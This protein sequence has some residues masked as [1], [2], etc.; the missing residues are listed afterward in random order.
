VADLIIIRLHPIKP[1]DSATFTSYLSKLTISAFDLTFAETKKGVPIGQATGVWTPASNNPADPKLKDFSP[2][3]PGIF[4][5]FSIVTSGLSQTVELEAVA[6]AVIVVNAPVGHT[7]YQTSDLHLEILNN[8]RKVL[9]ERLE[10]NV[11]IVK[12]A[13]LSINPRDYISAA[14]SVF[15]GLPDPGL[16]LNPGG[17]AFIDLPADGKAPLFSNVVTNVNIVLGKDPGGGASLASKSPLTA[18]QARQVAREITWNRQVSPPPTPPTPSGS[19]LPRPRPL[20]EMYTRP[21]TTAGLDVQKA[22][23]DREQFEASLSGF[24]ATQ[25]AKADRVAKYVFAASAALQAEARSKSPGQV[26]FSFPVD[27]AA[28]VPGTTI[29]QAEVALIPAGGFT[30]HFDVPAEYFYALGVALG[31]TVSSDQR[32]RLATLEDEARIVAELQRAIDED[33]ITVPGISPENA[34]RRLVALGAGTT[35]GLPAC[36]L[37]LDINTLLTAPGG[38]LQFM[39][40][41]INAFW[42][43]NPFPSGHFE[44]VLSAVTGQ[45][46]LLINAIKAIPVTTLAA[47]KT[48]TTAD[49]TNFF[50]PG[51]TALLPPFTAPGTPA[52]RVAAFIR[53]VRNFFDVLVQSGPLIAPTPDPIPTIA[54]AADD[55]IGAFIAAYDAQ[56]VAAFA[57]GLP[58]DPS[59]EAQ[60]L[61]QAFPGD[62]DARTWLAETIHLIDELFQITKGIVPTTLRFSLMEALYARGFVSKA[63]VTALSPADFQQAL[64]GTVAFPF[65]G[66]IHTQAGSGSGPSTPTSGAFAPVNPDGSL[67]NCIPPWHLSPLGPVEYLHE[68]LLASADS[69]CDD[70]MPGSRRPLATL[71]GARRGPLGSLHAT[72]ANVHTP[73]PLIDIVNENLEALAGGAVHG[74][75][76][77]TS[78]SAL[79]GH[80]LRPAGV[81]TCHPDQQQPFL[82]DPATLFATMAEHSSPATPVDRPAAYATL[83]SDFTAPVLPYSQPLDIIRTYLHELGTSRFQTMRRFRE[84]ITEFVI[85]PALEPVDFQQHLWRYPVRI[86]TARE[87][88]GISPE[89]Y[90][91][92]YTNDIATAPTAGRLLLRELYGFDTDAVNDTAWTE[93][94]V[95]VPE[96]LKR[97]GLSYCELLEL[98]RSEFVVFKRAGREPSFPDCEPCCEDDVVIEFVA[99]SALDQ[100]LGQLAVFI[101]LWRTLQRVRHAAYTFTQLRDICEVLRL[102]SGTSINPDFIRQLAALQMLRDDLDLSL[103]T[104]HGNAAATGA[105][106]TPLLALWVGPAATHWQWAVDRLLG[107][108]EDYAEARHAKEHGSGCA[109]H[110][111]PEFMKI[112]GDNLDPLSRLAL[113]DPAG[114]DTWFARPASTLRFAEVLTKIYLSDFSVGEILYLFAPDMHLDGDDPFPEQDHNEALDLPFD[115]PEEDHPFGL[116]SLRRNLLGVEVSDEDAHTWTWHRMVRSLE[117][118]FG[119]VPPAG[120]DP[121]Q[122]LGEH[123]FP[124]RLAQ[125]GA[126]VSHDQR[127]YRVPLDPT[128][129]GL[130]NADPHGPF[131]YDAAT[132]T[133]HAQ[134]PLRDADVDCQLS[135]VDQLS[136]AEQTA[137]TGLYFSPRADLAPFAFL[138]A[139]FTSAERRLI[140]EDNEHERWAYFRHAFA[141]FHARCRVVA[142]HLAEHVSAATDRKDVDPVLAWAV[143]RRL[144]ADEN[145]AV[146]GPWEQD[147]GQ[148][149]AANLWVLPNG[150]AFAALLGLTGTGLFGRVTAQGVLAWEEVRGPMRAFGRVRND[151][152]TPYPTILPGLDLALSSAQLKFAILRNGLALRDGDGDRLGGAEGFSVVWQ[153]VLLVEHPGTYEFFAGAPTERGSLPD[154]EAAGRQRWRVTLQRGQKTWLLLNHRMPGEKAPSAQAEPLHLR[155]GAYQLVVEFEQEQPAFDTAEHA[156]PQHSG[157]EIKH[158]G[159][160]TDGVAEAIRIERL[161]RDVKDGPLHVPGALPTP[162]ADFLATHYSSSL[163]DIRR[164]YQRAFKA[165]LFAH[166]LHLSAERSRRHSH[167][168]IDFLLD[169]QER[170][171]GTSY[172]PATPAAP[173]ASHHAHFN[174]NFLPVG[175]SY[176]PP[177][178]AADDRVDPS[179]KRRQA[180][181][182]WFERLHDY[183]VMRR[184]VRRHHERVWLLFLEAENQQPADPTA[185]LLH[186]GVDLTHAS[187]LL[188]YYQGKALDF[189]DLIDER[190]AIRLW[191]GDRWIRKVLEHFVPWDIA[192]AKPELWASSDDASLAVGTANLTKFVQDGCIERGEPRRYEDLKRADDRLREHARIALLAYLCGMNRVALPFGAGQFVKEPKDLSAL[193]LLD[194]EA[195]TCERASRIEEAITAVQTFVE[196]ARLGLDSGLAVSEAFTSMWDR[197]FATFRIWQACKRR[198]TYRENWVEWL[199]L[200]QARKTEAYRFLESELRRSTLTA[201]KAGGM[202]YWPGPRLPG[203]ARLTALQD[204]EPSHLR[205]IAQPENLVL[206]GKPARDARPSWLA[207]SQQTTGRAVASPNTLVAAPPAHVAE[208]PLWIQS[209]IGLGTQFL[210]IAAA[211]EP[212][213]SSE[214]MPRDHTNGAC[215]VQCGQVHP[216]VMDEYYFWLVDS[217]YYAPQTFGGQQDADW[218]K[219]QADPT[220]D[221]ERADQLPSLLSWATKPMVRL[222]WCRVHNGEFQPMRKSDEGAHV[223]AAG[224]STL[225]LEGRTS[226]SL[227]FSITNADP[228]PAGHLDPSPWGFRYDLASDTAAVLPQVVAPP[229]ALAHAGGLDAYPFFAYFEPGAPLEP[230]LFSPAIAVAGVLRTHCQYEAALKW[231]ELY[232]RP[233]EDDNRWARCRDQQAPSP[234]TPNTLIAPRGPAQVGAPPPVPGNSCC[235]TT[236]VSDAQVHERA[237]LLL[238]LETLLQFSKAATCGNSPEG[239]QR[240]RL[241]L[242][243]LAKILG[244]RPATIFSQ[245]DEGTP[246]TVAA[247]IPRFAPLN[248]RLM[249]IY[250]TLEDSQSSI[251]RCLNERRLHN[252]KSRVDMPYWGNDPVR[253]G[254]R[255]ADALCESGD[256]CCCP[257]SPYRFLF[258]VQK[259]H[260][261]TADVRA[262]GGELVAA[263][264]KGDA[265]CL[266][267]LRGAHERQLLNLAKEIRTH[268]WREADWQVQALKKTKEGAQAR[269]QHVATLM[270]NGLIGNEQDYLSSTDVSMTTRATGNAAEVVAQVMHLIPDFTIGVAGIAS[271]PVSVTALPIGTKVGNA[272]S[273]A[274]RILY[275]IA[276]ITGTSASVSLTEAGWDRRE[277]EWRQQVQLIDIEIEQIERQILA[278]ERRRDVALRQLNNHQQQVEQSAEMQDFLRDKFT[279]HALYLF[280]QQEAAALHRQTYD[281]AL[282]AARQAQRAFNLERGHTTRTFLP[283]HGWDSLHEGLLSGER[284]QVSLR[285]ME[286][287]YHDQNLREYELTKHISLRLQCPMAF[288]LLKATGRCELELPEWMF[289]RDYPGQY[290]RRI[291]NVSVTIPCVVGPYTGVHARLTLLSSSTRMDPALLDIKKCCHDAERCCPECEP[292][293]GYGEVRSDP[294]IV[295]QYGATEAVATSSGQNDT[296]MFELNFRDERYL[297]FEYAGAVSQWRLEL[298]PVNN[299]FDLGTVSDLVLHLNYTAREGGDVLRQAACEASACCLPGGGVR[300]FDLEQDFTEAWQ[301]FKGLNAGEPRGRLLRLRLAPNMFPFMQGHRRVQ[302]HRLVFFFEAPCAEPGRNHVL[303]LRPAHHAR[304]EHEEHCDCRLSH[305]TCVASA[306]LPCLFQG[307]LD[308]QVETLAPHGYTDVGVVR[309]PERIGRIDHAFLICEYRATDVEGC[310]QELLRC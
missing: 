264:E 68:A 153:G 213:A 3:N 47:L 112:V 238:Y 211:G 299:Q 157:F 24:Y 275:T 101:R 130:W 39:G 219:T 63:G 162:A 161:Y 237:I 281:L 11:P 2:A 220:P 188:H 182:D 286:K 294:R 190:W 79:A 106:R 272:F 194:V 261:I 40:A 185:L 169:H 122:S 189:S 7:E 164:T 72:A 274:A 18:A 51:N 83:K 302:V 100:A 36:P 38:W 180:L 260:E 223:V 109:R 99:P 27:P 92:L 12:M 19:V 147:S 95:R 280:L 198:K 244:R 306:A 43:P 54:I 178:A 195:G 53:Q 86:D 17:D 48:R 89:E 5:H 88:L 230:S 132:K 241:I 183:S 279:S 202:E 305:V 96:F 158:K 268:E 191:R 46:Q 222:A 269:R 102:F 97:T 288:L 285:Q 233:L 59:A 239:L 62:A 151:Q 192:A 113:F 71:I 117:H 121:L 263:F 49:W 37:N 34:A 26:G 197:T 135:Q 50:L 242:D 29:R 270:A 142:A 41:D 143:L 35:Q 291:K 61:Q 25:E 22:D 118:E 69:T 60:A 81:E 212:M 140:E 186:L 6:T 218:G 177:T 243:T 215:C 55:P 23:M 78:P 111:S 251:H 85:N 252:G 103:G 98:W 15:F 67:V 257:R 308:T 131:G 253:G 76:Y 154:C 255:T 128:K 144:L 108:I 32:Y 133:L 87:Y 267:A 10:F 229:P 138:F 94:V 265:E 80:D 284:L 116:W 21:P 204:R 167:S 137:V 150:G 8:G 199:D 90:D 91:L 203:H 309:F 282:C 246:Q 4:Q 310:Q 171:Q 221:W 196:R 271:T 287:A 256:D 303:E 30:L 234:D 240:A 145:R 73:L 193:L 179:L 168:E 56:P 70:P 136:S 290:M 276:D 300:F 119:Y 58:I 165:L 187:A 126:S 250:N 254:W 247:F 141:L 123:F 207:P 289:D 248:P 129:P 66:S 120:V 105:D 301:Q 44:L 110:R 65:A 206:R 225:V 75:V 304:H 226:D 115:L 173:F 200:E 1:T 124:E 31:S 210:R 146:P 33:V 307:V 52:E 127:R 13:P 295:H 273:A 45:F 155:R 163:R 74:V 104:R 175:D 224:S 209:A 77:D 262:L 228:L 231:Y 283:E 166:R 152:N 28:A 16:G 205:Q 82:H 296:G 217:E 93:I 235:D 159:P 214:F 57:F 232:F 20:E 227:R 181:F 134:L 236:V 160:D 114:P 125:E 64:T 245:D 278:S 42:K 297:P 266:A 208:L 172:F 107:Q 258:L 184:D 259:A 139:N 298:P 293:N 292:G 9:D 249:E 277:Q 216:P 148:P 174:L 176:K 84:K 149:P 170:F 156:C 14:P 201:P